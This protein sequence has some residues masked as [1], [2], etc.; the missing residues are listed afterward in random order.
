MVQARQTRRLV[1]QCECQRGKLMTRL[2]KRMGS[3]GKS[4]SA[5]TRSGD[6]R[7]RTSHK[8][9]RSARWGASVASQPDRSLLPRDAAFLDLVEQGLVAH[10]ELLGRTTS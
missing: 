6:R 9:S 8:E 2:G 7:N 3:V 1:E 10:A 5:G 4:A